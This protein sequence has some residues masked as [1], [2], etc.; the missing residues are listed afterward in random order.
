MTRSQGSLEPDGIVR[1]A[2]GLL[3]AERGVTN[4][5]DRADLSVG[6][7]APVVLPAAPPFLS[8]RSDGVVWRKHWIERD[9]LVV[10][11]VDVALVEVDDVTSTITFD[12]ELDPELE[13]HLVFDHV[14]PLVL[15]RQGQIVLHGGVISR[16]DRGVVLV[17]SS[18][19]GKSTLTAFAW[20]Q[21]WTVGGDDGAVLYPS[22]RPRT[23][24]TYPTIRLTPMATELLGI[25]PEECSPVFGKLRLNGRGRH[26]FRGTPVD[27]HAVAI[28]EPVA[29]DELAGF[30]PLNPLD[31]HAQLFGSAFHADFSRSDRL[32]ALVAG[33]GTIVERAVVGRLFVP[34]GKRGLADAE[35]QLRRLL[36]ASSAPTSVPGRSRGVG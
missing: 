20:R 30:E 28:I 13:Q 27:L 11:L 9:R 16:G 17:G 31:A 19:A 1:C 7:F 26:A 5:R 12:R 18:G 14:L 10:D 35:E 21:G 32:P 3:I 34:R 23:E 15:A 25:D 4:R 22:E 33:L 36:D 29:G 24:A 8:Q 6:E 2:G